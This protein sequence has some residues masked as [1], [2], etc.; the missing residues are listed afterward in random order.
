MGTRVWS[1]TAVTCVECHTKVVQQLYPT[2]DRG[3]SPAPGDPVPHS[4]PGDRSRSDAGAGTR[5]DTVQGTGYCDSHSA[6]YKPTAVQS[7]NPYRGTYHIT[8]RLWR[9]MDLEYRDSRADRPVRAVQ[10]GHG[11]GGR[12]ASGR[13]RLRARLTLR[14]RW[15]NFHTVYLMQVRCSPPRRLAAGPGAKCITLARPCTLHRSCVSP[16]E[17]VSR[18]R[19][20]VHAYSC[21]CTGRLAPKPRAARPPS[22]RE[23]R[24]HGSLVVHAPPRCAPQVDVTFSFLWSHPTRCMCR[25]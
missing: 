23:G 7:N 22:Q 16:F 24:H 4:S 19:F 17:F 1:L 18:P 11:R 14:A 10:G 21:R 12:S 6:C 9:A 8:V 5:T 13:Q 15:I 3:P 25:V 2:G 20:S